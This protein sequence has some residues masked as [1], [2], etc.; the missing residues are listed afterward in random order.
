MSA[1]ALAWLLHQS[2][3]TATIIGP[4]DP[5]QLTSVLGVPDIELTPD[6][7]AAIDGIF[8]PCGAAPEAYAW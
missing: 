8:P 3:V 4:A 7:L 6:T 1:V 5:D 2:P